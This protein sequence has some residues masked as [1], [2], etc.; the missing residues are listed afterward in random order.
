M[1]DILQIL[2]KEKINIKQDV[3]THLIQNIILNFISLLEKMETGI[4]GK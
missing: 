3:I 2:Q 4:I 1:L